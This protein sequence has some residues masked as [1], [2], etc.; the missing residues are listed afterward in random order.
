[1][2]ANKDQKITR[3]K[4]ADEQIPQ[5]VYRLT[6]GCRRDDIRGFAFF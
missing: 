2:P 3:S 5:T 6:H 1:M 4:S